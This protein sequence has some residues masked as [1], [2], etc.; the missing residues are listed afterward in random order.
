MDIIGAAKTCGEKINWWFSRFIIGKHMILDVERSV[1][2]CRY[3][4]ILEIGIAVSSPPLYCLQSLT[5]ST[6]HYL[7]T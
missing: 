7:I 6:E 1:E 4:T 2:A 3:L 5:M